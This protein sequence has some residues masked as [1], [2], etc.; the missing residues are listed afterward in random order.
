MPPANHYVT[1]ATAKTRTKIQPINDASDDSETAGPKLLIENLL[2]ALATAVTR[3]TKLEARFVESTRELDAIRD[4]LNKS[5][6]RAKTDALTGLPNRHALDEFFRVA[7]IAAI[8]KGEPLSVPL[9]DIDH[10]KSF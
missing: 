10:F 1:G 5:E 2:S 6:E 8:E 7:Q 9:I 4:S 3:A